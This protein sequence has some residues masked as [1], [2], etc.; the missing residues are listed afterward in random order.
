MI[1][2]SLNKLQLTHVAAHYL[3]I[4]MVRLGML[5]LGTLILLATQ[6]LNKW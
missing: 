1:H 2:L 3:D 6:N 5:L 4:N